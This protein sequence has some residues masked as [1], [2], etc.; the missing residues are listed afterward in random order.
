MDMLINRFY[1]GMIS[2]TYMDK[3]AA[4]HIVGIGGIGTS[5][6]ARF[7]LSKGIR[8]TGSDLMLSEITRGLADEG[9]DIAI[10]AH[11]AESLP[12]GVDLVVYTA[13]LPKQNLELQ[14]A[15]RR[16]ILVKTY[17][18]A[19]GDITRKYRAIT[20]SGSHGK[21]TTTALAALVLEQGY[22]DPT[23]IIGTK[24]NE[25]GGSNFR[26]GRSPYLVLEADEWNRSFLHYS[27]E[28]AIATNI[29]RE[30]VDTYE[31]PAALQEA[32]QEYFEKLPRRGRIIANEDDEAL[33]DVAKKF[34]NQ[35]IWYSRTHPE[36]AFLRKYLRIPGEHNVSNALAALHLGRLFGVQETQILRALSSY[37]GAWRRFEFRGIVNGAYLIS[38]YAHHPNEIRATIQAA[39]ERHP[40][41]RIWCVYQPHQRQRTEYLWD[42]FMGAFDGADRVSLLPIYDVAGREGND[43]NTS[44][45]SKNLARELLKR[46]KDVSHFATLRAIKKHICQQ[47]QMGDVVLIMGAGDIYNL[48]RE[49][50]RAT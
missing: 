49:L 2:V 6:L 38:D 17:A 7:Y 30:H 43:G 29:D 18:E 5:A 20:I 21:S 34:G 12:R 33:R 15:K 13:A 16:K 50:E 41:R 31:T 10:G 45:T 8:V 48:T 22:H 14:A 19:L 47:T 25:F 35:V 3:I 42:D 46:G 39:R 24:L 9:V 23:V 27:P 40:L 37:A 36:A 26:A 4:V 1:R 11:K 28:V 44:V 32:F